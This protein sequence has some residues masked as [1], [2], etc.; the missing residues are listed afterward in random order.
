MLQIIALQSPQIVELT[1]GD[2]L[3]VVATFGYRGPAQQLTLYA[4]IGNLGLFGFDEIISA[5]QPLYLPQSLDSFTTCEQSVD[6]PITDAVSPGA[7]YDLMAK[8][9]EYQSETEVR[10]ADV[11]NIA[12]AASPWS[13]LAA[14]MMMSMMMA[15]VSQVMPQ[16]QG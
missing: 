2:R 15:I 10:V 9:K 8:M 6:I 13:G 16:E 4:S 3:R 5:Q 7:G 1:V 12:G 14:V 11:I